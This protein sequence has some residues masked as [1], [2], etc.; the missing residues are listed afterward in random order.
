MG[1]IEGEETELI[2]VFDVNSEKFTFLALPDGFTNV[3][4]F[5]RCLASFKGNLAFITCA[6]NE[7]FGF[8]CQYSVWVMKEYGVA[9]SWNKHSVILIP[10]ERVVYCLAF[11]EYGSLLLCCLNER[12]ESRY[13]LVDTETLH[14][15]KD[16][17]QCPSFVSNFVESLILLDGAYVTSY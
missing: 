12:L 13:V 15:K 1:R 14:E 5:Q 8:P 2:M 9:E 3:N 7:Q 4:I 10:F 6:C 17:I 11:T 16:P